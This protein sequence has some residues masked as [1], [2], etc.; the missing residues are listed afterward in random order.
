[1]NW[2][3]NGSVSIGKPETSVLNHTFD[4]VDAA[5]GSEQ[6]LNSTF[7]TNL[8]SNPELNLTFERTSDRVKYNSTFSRNNPNSTFETANRT[9][10]ASNRTFEASNRTFEAPNRTFEAKNIEVSNKTFEKDDLAERNQR[11]MSE[12]RLSSASSG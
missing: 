3:F 2:L 8:N 9:F 10:E 5:L 4:T 6:G 11:K 7:N 1:M 12:D